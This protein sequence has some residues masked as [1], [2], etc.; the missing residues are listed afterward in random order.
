[1]FTRQAKF[2]WL[3]QLQSYRVFSMMPSDLIT[4]NDVMKDGNFQ[5]N[6]LFI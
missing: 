6:N 2:Y 5:S 1:M 3:R 4:A